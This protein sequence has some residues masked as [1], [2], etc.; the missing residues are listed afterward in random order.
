MAAAAPP[1]ATTTTLAITSGGSAVT[2]VAS[3]SV[4]TLTATVT[5]GA[6]VTQG[7]VNFCDATAT[8]CEDIHIVG[9]AQLTSAGTAV[10]K[11]RPAIGSHSYKAVFAATATNAGSS[12]SASSLNVPGPLPTTTTIAQSVDNFTYTLTATVSGTG[13]IAP[14]G[15]VSFLDTNNGNAVVGTQL[16]SPNVLAFLNPSNPATGTFPDSIAVGDFNGDGIPD[17]A[18][19]NI[20]STGV[21]VDTITILLGNGDGTFNTSAP[22]LAT[23]FTPY[24][25]TVG[26]FNG[27]GKLDLAVSVAGSVSRYAQVFLGNGDGTFTPVSASSPVGYG[28]AGIVAGDFN[29]DGI[30]DL[31]LLNSGSN[32]LTVLLGNGDGTFT[33]TAVGPATG[34]SPDAIAVGDFNGDGIPDLAV[35]NTANDTVSILLANGDGTFTAAPVSPSLATVGC[36]PNQLVV[37]DF[38]GDGFADL[39]VECQSIAKVVVLLGNGQGGFS[40]L[41]T[42]PLLFATVPVGMTV[43]DF[44]GDGIVDVAVINNSAP[45]ESFGILDVFLGVGDGTFNAQ[46]EGILPSDIDSTWFVAAGDFTGSGLSD[47]AISIPYLAAVDVLTGEQSASAMVT[48]S[49]ANF[50]GEHL[51][52]ASYPGDSQYGASISTTTSL[53]AATEPTTLTLAWSAAPGPTG[54]VL[55]L[56]ATLS[57]YSEGSHS[58][59]GETI[60]FTTGVYAVPVTGILS[61]G[62]ASVNISTLPPGDYPRVLANYAGDAYLSQSVA[63]L[64]VNFGA[65][66][67]TMAASPAAS[68]V[69]Q[70]IT[71]TATL[72]P[73]TAGSHSTDGETVTFVGE[74][75]T[76]DFLTLTGT[77]SGGVATVTT[78]SIPPG[79]YGSGNPPSVIRAFFYG[80][81]FLATSSATV[82]LVVA[83]IQPGLTLTGSPT[84][85]TSGQS[86]T[87]TAT[88]SGSYP[89]GLSGE[90]ITFSSN[91]N[92]IG[93]GNLVSGVA[94]LRTSS[95]A[96]GID[97]LTAVYPGDSNNFAATSNIALEVVSLA[98]QTATNVALTVTKSGSAVTSVATGSPVTLTATV[99]AGGAPV[100]P[101]TVT[102]CDLSLGG[103]CGVLAQVGSA[104]L[105]AAGT[106]AISLRLGIGSHKLAAVFNGKSA[107]ANS[108]STVSPLTVTGL[109]ETATEIAS[110]SAA[111]GGYYLQETIHGFGP[112]GTPYPTGTVQ[113]ID[114]SASNYVLDTETFYDTFYDQGAFPK[115]TPFAA[116]GN[117]P[118]SIAPGDFNH[119][120]IADLV[121]ANSG[122]NTV[123]VLLGDG[124]ATFK[125]QTTYAT[126]G[127]PYSVAV[128]DFNGDG[129]PDLAVANFTD[130]TVSVLLGNNDGTFQT[131]QIYAAGGG[132]N[133]VVV[134]DLN[135]DGNLDLAVANSTDGTVS[136]LLGKGDGSFDAQQTFATGNG[137]ASIFVGDFNGDGVPD[138]A[139][140]NNGDNTVSVL[141]GVGDGTFHT[142][143]PYATGENPISVTAAD[144]L[145]N[146]VLDLAVANLSGDFLSILN[147]NGDG[148]FQA[149]TIQS[150]G[151]GPYSVVTGSFSGLGH[152]D[153]ATA[154]SVGNSVTL[155][156]N[157]G[158]G[159]FMTKTVGT[160]SIGP[161]AI[162]VTDLNG[163]GMA[164]MAVLNNSGNSVLELVNETGPVAES[165]CCPEIYI[166]L[167]GT[168]VVVGE[169]SGD[170]TFAAEN[171][172]SITITIPRLGDS[173]AL[174]SGANPTN[175]GSPLLLTA[176]L[177]AQANSFV[178]S[179]GASISFV[180]GSTVLGTAT[181]ES[182]VATLDT[183]A[184]PVG[185]NSVMAQFAG[186]ADYSAASSSAVNVTVR[187]AAL[188]VTGPDLSRVFGAVNPSLNGTVNG[189][190]N[191][192]TFTVTGTTTATPTSPVGAYTVVPVVSG[193]DLADYNVVKVNGK[194]TV[195]PAALTVTG[196]DVSRAFGAA[197]PSLNGMVNGAV[198]GDTFTVTGT[199]TATATSAV[200]AYA[201]VPAVSGSDVADYT[202]VKV[203]GKLT[204]T[205]AALT[206]TG[207]DLSRVFGAANPSLNGTV[208][209][210][211]NGDT[212]TVMGTTTATATSPVG[213]YAVVPS[214]SGS[215]LADYTVAKVN[216]KLTVTQAAPTVAVAPGAS[217]IS[218]AEALSVSVTVTGASGATAPSG[219]VTLSSGSYTSAATTLKSG[220]ATISVPAGSLAV[221]ADTLTANYSGDTNYVA[222]SGAASVTVTN[223]SFAITGTAVTVEPGATT[224]NTSTI[225]VTP[226]GGFTGSVAL[227]TAVTASPANAV[228]PP[229]LSFGTTTPVG[230]TGAAAGTATLTIST[231]ASGTG[232]CTS[233]NEQPRNIP[234]YAGGGAVLACVFLFGIPARRRK[235]RNVL[236][237]VAILV[238]IAG[239]M[240]ACGSGSGNKCTTTST[241]PTTPGTYTVTV[242]G[243]SGTITETGTVT[244]T[245][246]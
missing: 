60:S 39:A 176:T 61:S 32:S 72:S 88:L 97:S 71:F 83:D 234:W 20:D 167:P 56:T 238:G 195:T 220:S 84:S 169:Y 117:Q 30:P 158:N 10:F 106:A 191:G 243:A 59:D 217:T 25:L 41:T 105:S 165:N 231:T 44:N 205:P 76:G 121:V 184:L 162:A 109:R 210:A 116:T 133:S 135:G 227:T 245:V 244:L 211:V 214:V 13:S 108:V 92:S 239:G 157:Q 96:R 235:L 79:V 171:S 139:V 187:P 237:M 90:T 218:A 46:D 208:T 100:S 45:R 226:G 50:S 53:A 182:G 146:G 31:A 58:T 138:L 154:N 42:V 166:G 11:F 89:T 22:S 190:V 77:L 91:G 40:P 21:N 107:D 28:T 200:G 128:G 153:L 223:P 15:T 118:F 64:D 228:M 215:D 199:T 78:S 119:D 37:A 174:V 66:T 65:T 149:Q 172:N 47:L 99:T 241:A 110:Y 132:P 87:L 18:V 192:D 85:I 43:G 178:S 213:A 219:T 2:S 230:I 222:E 19:A 189:A 125:A 70:P 136:I 123:S 161:I 168:N 112:F 183:T 81:A 114:Q 181:L 131:Q 159:T 68:V 48:Y 177:T 130:N 122:S 229:T 55:T 137:P 36:V 155:M 212:F 124:D 4:V 185:I 62:V 34:P 8:Y 156:M 29:Q 206:V 236:G 17:L 94:T 240:L 163:D 152:A 242:T 150:T 143:V 224:G 209:G 9:T 5:A 164:D 57:P 98:G 24:D 74:Y 73:Y 246:Q 7:L 12:S 113:F 198:N 204:V 127:G 104:Q 95:L 188:T 103:T 16:L 151:E 201:V 175:Y 126:G 82:P 170:S 233:F 147:G 202:V 3:G 173:L 115:P 207:P 148:T 86:V 38:N 63:G 216:G 6:A 179:N 232:P 33:A 23:T 75:P 141:L 67:L 196:P 101:G 35:G 194:L 51:V 27:D 26:D 120:G 221:G 225:S 160:S 134:A 102:F 1:V 111:N 142:Q 129:N 69:G 197:N 52:E 186:N 14:T 140:A 193:S 203:N 145:G 49:P 93:T 80:D 180:S 144:L 54:Q